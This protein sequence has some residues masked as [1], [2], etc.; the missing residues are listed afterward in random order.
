MSKGYSTSKVAMA[1]WLPITTANHS[2]MHQ[3]SVTN[4]DGKHTSSVWRALTDRAS[5]FLPPQQG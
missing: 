4:I 2:S 5:Q 1:K 3:G